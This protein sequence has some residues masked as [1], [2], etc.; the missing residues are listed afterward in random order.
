MQLLSYKLSKLM[1]VVLSWVWWSV[2]HT[3]SNSYWPYPEHDVW[4]LYALYDNRKQLS[5]A[6]LSP[7]FL[8]MYSASNYYLPYPGLMRLIDSALYPEHAVLDE[9]PWSIVGSKHRSWFFCSFSFLYSCP[10]LLM[11]Q[12]IVIWW[13]TFDLL[14]TNIC[15]IQSVLYLMFEFMYICTLQET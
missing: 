1:T 4:S 8:S 9:L 2:F 10:L 14:L 6:V 3:A 12:L 11:N 7:S 5:F 15:L 13:S